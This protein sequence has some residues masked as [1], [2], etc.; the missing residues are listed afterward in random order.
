M[1]ANVTMN[2]CYRY[3]TCFHCSLSLSLSLRIVPR[4]F[5][6]SVPKGGALTFALQGDV[7]TLREFSTPARMCGKILSNIDYL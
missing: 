3:R 4:Y 1:H 6:V 7:D 5:D 2:G